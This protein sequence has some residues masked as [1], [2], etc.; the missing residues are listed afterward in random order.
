MN[1]EGFSEDGVSLIELPD[2]VLE[3][4]AGVLKEMSAWLADVTGETV[5]PENLAKSLPG[6]ADD[7][8][9]EAIGILYRISRR[10]PSVKQLAS[11]P[12]FVDLSKNLMGAQ[13]VSCCNFVCV[14]IDM[15]G[16]D[17]FLLGPHQDFHYIQGS[18][19]GITFW[20]PLNAVPLEMGPPS[21]VL[22][23]HKN[24]VLS[25]RERSLDETYGANG[26]STIELAALADWR[27]REYWSLPV[28]ESEAAVFSTLLVHQSGINQ[29]DQAR[30]SIQLRFDNLLDPVSRGKGYPEGLYLRNNFSDSYPEYVEH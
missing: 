8:H 4:K 17:N 13:L 3:L 2:Q 10:F 30:I 24:G 20:T 28:S 22:G 25:V 11:H 21:F 14:R 7:G 15:P 6:L 5:A 9:R 19:D 12:F 29:T 16:E 1:L 26:G 23:S 27:G 18:P